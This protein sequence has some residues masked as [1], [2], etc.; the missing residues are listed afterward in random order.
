[1]P[2]KFSWLIF[3]TL[4]ALSACSHNG[5]HSKK[6]HEDTAG[7]LGMGHS[8]GAIW[9]D[10]KRC[11]QAV[12]A[13][14]TLKREDGKLRV[15]TWNIRWF[16]DGRPGNAPDVDGTDI[17]WLACAIAY[18]DV[19]V[20]G[21]QEIKLT[22]RAKERLKQLTDELLH[23]TGSRW[24]W[25]ADECPTPSRQHVA[26]LYRDKAVSI[27]DLQSHGEIDPTAKAGH[28]AHCPGD[29]RPALGTYIK[30][31][32]GGVDFHFISTHLDSG[33]TQRD[34]DNRQK[35]FLRIGTVHDKR[36]AL[37]K[38]EDF[39]F[40]AD[41]NLMGCKNCEIRNSTQERDL[42]RQTLANLKRPLT[43]PKADLDCTEYYRGKG[44]TIDQIVHSTSMV[45]AQGSIQQVSGICA[46]AKCRKLK[47]ED[48][49]Y[50]SR[51]S[52]HCPVMLDID[53]KDLD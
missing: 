28:A 6:K 23:L 21:L 15:G 49:P 46:A 9:D 26:I 14:R 47:S 40:A 52:D 17:A 3:A 19:D 35:A 50:F 16:P 48:I 11:T 36:I 2:S 10:P 25:V 43:T 22:P 34:F 12:L 5:G 8:F 44:Y 53:D 18:T 29:L 27:S 1:M 38:D 24:L 51:L 32:S 42:L 39:I 45:E 30:S 31:K 20:L 37:N 41:F 4:Y 7:A 33:R 13:G